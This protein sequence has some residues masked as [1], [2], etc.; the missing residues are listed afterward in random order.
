MPQPK[1]IKV[2]ARICPTS[3]NDNYFDEEI[4]GRANK[5]AL[6]MACMRLIDS[7]P[8]N[9]PTIIRVQEVGSLSW[10]YYSYK[11]GD[12]AAHHIPKFEGTWT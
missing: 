7:L 8:H 11:A 2:Q 4:K 12:H 5:R 9:T 1:I 6:L 10:A 3:D